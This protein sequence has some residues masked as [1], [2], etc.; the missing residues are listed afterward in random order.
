MENSNFRA[1][2]LDHQIINSIVFYTIS[3]VDPQSIKTYFLTSRYSSLRDLHE[4]LKQKYPQEMKL[5][6][7]PPKK[8]FGNLN[9][10]FIAKRKKLLEDYFN[11]FLINAS[12][13]KDPITLQYFEMMEN[14][15]LN[16]I[17]GLLSLKDFGKP[18]KISVSRKYNVKMFF[19]EYDAINSN[20][21]QHK[22]SFSMMG[23]CSI[24]ALADLKKLKSGEM[25]VQSFLMSYNLVKYFL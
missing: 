19:D 12:L 16:N 25:H 20:H 2:F 9:E 3:M 5:P 18:L 17:N 21:L 14:E 13:V 6:E 23:F 4:S 1:Q 15:K 7:F 24:K 11:A 22:N 8:W 10:S